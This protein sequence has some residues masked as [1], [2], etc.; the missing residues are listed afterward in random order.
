M[1]NTA[2]A[3][4]LTPI[5]PTPPHQIPGNGTGGSV[6][7]GNNLTAL[8]WTITV[9]AG[10]DCTRSHFGC[11]IRTIS[12]PPCT[13]ERAPHDERDRLPL[14]QH[15]GR[16]AEQLPAQWAACAQSGLSP[17]GLLFS[18]H[19]I[20]NISSTPVS[21]QPP[22]HSHTR[23]QQQY[24]S[25][26]GDTLIIWHHGHETTYCE[27][28]FEGVVDHLNELGYDVRWGFCEETPHTG[29]HT[30]THTHGVFCLRC[31]L[32]LLTPHLCAG[33]HRH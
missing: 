4:H 8:V 31:I 19:A 20:N 26:I 18:L 25:S 21:A 11:R 29:T 16:C 9:G 2:E 27:P 33:N 17:V 23:S 15:V 24:A 12:P 6:S 3:L 28:N 22:P 7:W 5:P 10:Q 1:K 32:S 13:Q 30:H 14:A